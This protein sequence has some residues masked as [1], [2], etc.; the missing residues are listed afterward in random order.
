MKENLLKQLSCLVKFLGLTLGTEYEI[1]LHDLEKEEGSIVAIVN[2]Q[3]SGRSLGMPLTNVG[4]KMLKEATKTQDNL[5]KINYTGFTVS[6]QPLRSST[7]IIED[8][9]KPAAM[10]CINFDDSR[11]RNLS[12]QVLELC[13]PD[14][15]VQSQFNTITNDTNDCISLSS[16]IE[17]LSTD[18]KQVIYSAI[19]SAV[20]DDT[21]P[22]N[23][24]S[25]DEKL[26]IIE[27]LE[28]NG[29]FRV[30]GAV[31]CVA[32][33]LSSSQASIYR[34]LTQIRKGKTKQ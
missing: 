33:A 1:V 13:H 31:N 19:A 25:A 5:L 8:E 10:L 3:I 23:Y 15:Y 7:F 2:G 32:E 6:G 12:R 29:I 11:Y 27:T 17:E 21:L 22:K 16:S 9:G 30:K 24:L 28:H 20:G 4:L 18:P 34:Y 14:S 26:S